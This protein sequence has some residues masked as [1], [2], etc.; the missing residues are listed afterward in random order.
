MIEIKNVNQSYI[1]GK[2]FIENMNLEIENGVVFGFLGP[3]GGGK[4]TTIDRITGVLKIARYTR[5]F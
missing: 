1:K 2:N 3:N 4:T 5:S